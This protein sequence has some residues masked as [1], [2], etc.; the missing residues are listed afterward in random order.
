MKGKFI[1]LA[2]N[3][4]YN[5]DAFKLISGL[6]D[7]SIDALITDPPYSSGGALTAQRKKAPEQKYQ[8][9]GQEKKY[10]TFS[11]DVRDQRSY[12]KWLTYW[13][14]DAWPKLKEGGI[15]GLFTDW[16]QY[17]VTAEA[18]QIAGYQWLGVVTWDKTEA[19]RPQL[20]RFRNQAEYCLMAR[21]LIFKPVD[22]PPQYLLWAC[23]GCLPKERGVGVLPGVYRHYLNPNE[24]Q[25]MTAK[26]VELMRQIVKITTPGGVILDPFAGSGS[27]LVAAALEGYQ[28]IGGDIMPHNVEIAQTRIAEVKGDS[29]KILSLF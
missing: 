13:L 1:M 21:K 23:K 16:R 24:K 15:I 12:E 4:I 11:G 5:L 17:P 18:I 29:N 3:K 14:S 2:V 10:P 9:S 25:H 28:Y 19:A 27:T 6:A 26:P 8:Q 7:D 22:T 20:D